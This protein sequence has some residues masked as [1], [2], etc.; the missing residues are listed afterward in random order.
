M[1]D[2]LF[3]FHLIMKNF[4]AAVRGQ[5]DFDLLVNISRVNVLFIN[6]FIY[7][8]LIHLFLSFFRK[9]LI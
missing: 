7:L 6:S 4:Q 9:L 1:E 2:G 5:Y 3:V 8:F